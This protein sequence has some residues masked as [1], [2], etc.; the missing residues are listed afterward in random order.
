MIWLSSTKYNA[1]SDPLNLLTEPLTH[2]SLVILVSLA[3]EL[4]LTQCS[5]CSVRQ[6]AVLSEAQA[7]VSS[8]LSQVSGH[9]CDNMRC[10]IPDSQHSP[11]ER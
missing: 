2:C 1:E 5:Q 11:L 9:G 10:L 6:C 7:V 4:K 3:Q 8:K